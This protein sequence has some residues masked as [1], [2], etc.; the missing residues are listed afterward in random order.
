[1]SKIGHEIK[2]QVFIRSRGECECDIVSHGHPNFTCGRKLKV[3][4]YFHWIQGRPHTL[5]A[6]NIMV[7]CSTCHSLIRSSRGR[8][9]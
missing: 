7:V 3:R 5:D 2:Q 6:D 8:I 1:M 9:H 4:Y